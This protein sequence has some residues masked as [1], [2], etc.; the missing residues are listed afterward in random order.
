[1]I[2]GYPVWI[3]NVRSQ[4]VQGFLDLLKLN[5]SDCSTG[6]LAMNVGALVPV[7]IIIGY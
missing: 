2:S 1:M 5:V 7:V 4:L 6:A 3:Q